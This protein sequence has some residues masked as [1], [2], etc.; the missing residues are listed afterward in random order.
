MTVHTTHT[1]S[2]HENIFRIDVMV[3]LLKDTLGHGYHDTDYITT[4]PCFQKLQ[5][6]KV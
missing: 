1:V 6:V 2:T 5:L 4:K 3:T